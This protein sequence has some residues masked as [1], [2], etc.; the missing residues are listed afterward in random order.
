MG[1]EQVEEVGDV[2]KLGVVVDRCHRLAG[3][4]E[5]VVVLFVGTS[6][7]SRRWSNRSYTGRWQGIPRR[8]PRGLSL[9]QP[10]PD[11]LPTVTGTAK[12]EIA[13]GCTVDVDYTVAFRRTGD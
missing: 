9:P 5:Y 4:V 10:A 13:G 2:G 7:L 3:A 11:P 8:T 6:V 12:A 1:V